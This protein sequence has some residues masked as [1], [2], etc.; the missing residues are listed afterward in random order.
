MAEDQA[1]VCAPAIEECSNEPYWKNTIELDYNTPNIIVGL[2]TLANFLIP[3]LGYRLWFNLAG[4]TVAD[5]AVYTDQ[6]KYQYGWLVMY[7]GAKYIWG[8]PS[9]FWLISRIHDHTA[10]PFLLLVWWSSFQTYVTPLVILGTVGP[11]LYGLLDWQDS[12]SSVISQAEVAAVGVGYLLF[13]GISYY[14]FTDKW[15]YALY[16]YDEV[17]QERHEEVV[18]F[19]EPEKEEDLPEERA[20]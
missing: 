11:I 2:V 17:L 3:V 13:G 15:T 20:D 19:G 16:Y 14:V 18:Q 9:L 1:T 12:W 7:E 10:W 4:K 5:Q 8:P 6:S